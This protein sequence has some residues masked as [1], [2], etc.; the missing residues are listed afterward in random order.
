MT[1]QEFKDLFGDYNMYQEPAPL[2][3]AHPNRA[4][5]V[6]GA[7]KRGLVSISDLKILLAAL[8]IDISD[9]DNI[10]AAIYKYNPVADEMETVDRKKILSA[11]DFRQII[12]GLGVM[13]ADEIE[14]ALGVLELKD[15][16]MT[17]SD[18]KIA[19]LTLTDDYVAPTS[20]YELRG[21][22][23]V[24]IDLGTAFID[25]GVKALDV[26]GTDIS[27][28]VRVEGDYIDLYTPGN[29]YVDY[30]LYITDPNAP[31]GS[32]PDKTVQRKVTVVG[33]SGR[34]TSL[35]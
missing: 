18:L 25:P 28:Y 26:R 4:L 2:D 13:T 27:K 3:P 10:V 1:M 30:N 14:A 29:Y 17:L 20:V 23:S 22:A 11:T 6:K 8:G 15:A 24:E 34:G 32:T 35:K 19:L 21:P 33:G 9:F 31:A 12:V 16:S 7:E 5:Q